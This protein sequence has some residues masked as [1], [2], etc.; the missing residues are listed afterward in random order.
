MLFHV[1]MA[2]RHRNIKS[3]EHRVEMGPFSSS[4][5]VGYYSTFLL[6]LDCFVPFSFCIFGYCT[7]ALANFARA[8]AQRNSKLFMETASHVVRVCVEADSASIQQ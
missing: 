2:K 8:V 5:V 3:D 6:R 7:P 1:S 4:T